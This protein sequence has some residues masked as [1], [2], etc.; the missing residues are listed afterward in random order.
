MSTFNENIYTVAGVPSVLYPYW[1]VSVVLK[2]HDGNVIN[3]D[4][5]EDDATFQFVIAASDGENT[6]VTV[7]PDSGSSSDGITVPT[8]N[9]LLAALKS[10]ATNQDWN[11]GYTWSN[12][13]ADPST[14]V[15]F[16]A[17]N[18]TEVATPESARTDVTPS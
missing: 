9:S 12:S 13:E 3:S 6:G 8:R 4:S 1:I 2:D 5:N 14:P 7:L 11:T 17:V 18:I 15:T 10:W 16:Y